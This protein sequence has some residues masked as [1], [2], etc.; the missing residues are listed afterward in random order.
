MAN[1]QAYI[2]ELL[3]RKTTHEIHGSEVH[4][5]RGCR[6][7]WNW[8]FRDNLYPPTTAKPLEFGIAF[9]KAF[10]TMFCPTT[11]RFQH[12]VLGALAEKTFVEEC[13]SQRAAYLRA[14]DDYMLEG[15]MQQDYDER[16][17]L[18]RG[19]IK[20]FVEKQLPAI[21]EEF[22]PTHVEVS[23]DVP[24]FDFDGN[25]L[26][27]KCKA[28]RR[29]FAKAGGGRWYGNPVVFSGRVDMIV[30]DMQ[31]GYWIW[32]LPSLEDSGPVWRC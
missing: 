18:G 24:L 3:D 27:C 13:E 21:Q 23:F 2:Q 1:L 10:E 28:C 16:L 30:H 22:V 15:D 11:W 14:R 8:V 4:S 26:V 29:A 31:G 19:M 20:Y 7:R 6:R 25:H 5:F 17:E 12:V 32:D 9:H